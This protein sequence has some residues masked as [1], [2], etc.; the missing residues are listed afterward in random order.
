MGSYWRHI[1]SDHPWSQKLV[2]P[3]VTSTHLSW[4]AAAALPGAEQ[5]VELGVEGLQISNPLLDFASLRMDNYLQVVAGAHSRA[6]GL[7]HGGDCWQRNIEA[8]QGADQGLG[9]YQPTHQRAGSVPHCGLMAAADPGRNRSESFSLKR[10]NG[11]P[12]HRSFAALWPVPLEAVAQPLDS[13]AGGD[14]ILGVVPSCYL[15]FCPLHLS[16]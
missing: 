7:Q 13:P 14:P 6:A 4:P 1:T 9:R 8:P 16:C 3:S 5:S 11:Q 10:P 2:C 15:C 12:P